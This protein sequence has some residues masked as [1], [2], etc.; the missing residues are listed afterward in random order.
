M[1]PFLL[2]YAKETGS[3]PQA[4]LGSKYYFDPEDD[5][6]HRRK[7]PDNPP[8]IEVDDDDDNGPRTKKHDVEKG[9]D[10]KDRQMWL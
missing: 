10:N 2:R 5:L 4:E 7:H 8:A 3:P 6:L 9:D 1:K